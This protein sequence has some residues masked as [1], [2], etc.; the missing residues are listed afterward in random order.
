GDV[1]ALGRL[2]R[3]WTTDVEALAV[4]RGTPGDTAPWLAA[5]NNDLSVTVG[6]G[7]RLFERPWDLPAPD[8][9]GRV[10][11]MRHDRLEEEWSG[12]DL[13]GVVAGRDGTT[14]GHAVRRMVA[15]AAP[16][17]VLRWRQ[18]G[19]WQPHDPQGRP[20]TGRNL[21]GQV[22]GSA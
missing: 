2:L 22:D 14:V 18:A 8:G 9:F 12:G 13:A 1:E 11:A 16:F 19:S 20:Q 6:L 10:P 15:D 4:G 3:V 21:F 17:A 7:P 5:G